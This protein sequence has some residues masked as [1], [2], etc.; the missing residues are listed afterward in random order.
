MCSSKVAAML[1]SLIWTCYS[2]MHMSISRLL[3]LAIPVCY[4]HDKTLNCTLWPPCWLKWQE[5][6]DLLLKIHFIYTHFLSWLKMDWF[7]YN[8]LIFC[9]VYICRWSCGLVMFISGPTWKLWTTHVCLFLF[10]SYIYIYICWDKYSL[11][12]SDMIKYVL[13]FDNW[14]SMV[15]V[16]ICV[17][18][19]KSV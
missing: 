3:R 17:W 18:R 2:L 5:T 9:F 15:N 7:W 6:T 14:M 19:P 10:I 12:L 4:I 13:Q 16:I 1:F 8:N 11:V